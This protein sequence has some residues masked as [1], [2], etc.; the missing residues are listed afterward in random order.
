[1]S[2]SCKDGSEMYK[3]AWSMY[4]F[5]FLRFLLQSLP[6]CLS[7]G[8]GGATPPPPP[9]RDDLRFSNTTGILQKKNYVVYWCRSRARDECTPPKKYPRSAPVNLP[10]VV[11]QKFCYPGNVMS[12]FSISLLLCNICLLAGSEVSHSQI[13]TFLLSS[14]ASLSLHYPGHYLDALLLPSPSLHAAF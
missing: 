1:M 9:P 4:K 6:R 12:H 10:I 7:R 5:V 11:I 3:K 13:S 2:Q 8:A 14:D